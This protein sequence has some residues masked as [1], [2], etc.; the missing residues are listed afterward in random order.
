[1]VF[2]DAQ[3]WS[4]RYTKYSKQTIFYVIFISFLFILLML[5]GKSEIGVHVSSNICCLIC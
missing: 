3:K 5:D 1:M 2:V 4:L